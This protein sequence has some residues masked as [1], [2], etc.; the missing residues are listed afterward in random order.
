MEL[1][2]VRRLAQDLARTSWL[3]G[4]ASSVEVWMGR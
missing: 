4:A 2:E 1:A 3:T